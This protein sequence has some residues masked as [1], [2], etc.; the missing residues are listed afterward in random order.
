MLNPLEGVLSG[1]V[2]SSSAG[3]RIVTME[4]AGSAVSCLVPMKTPRAMTAMGKWGQ[5]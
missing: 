1:I 2:S 4:A 5:S 3:Q